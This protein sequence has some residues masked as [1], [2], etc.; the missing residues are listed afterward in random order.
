MF[1]FTLSY[2]GD[3]VEHLFNAVK[4]QMYSDDRSKSEVVFE[5]KKLIFKVYAK[6]L[7]ALRATFNAIQQMITINQKLDKIL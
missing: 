3:N 6:D 4:N 1:E 5:D 2:D 7:V